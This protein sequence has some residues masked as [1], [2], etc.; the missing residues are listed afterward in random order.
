MLWSSRLTLL[1]GAWQSH[2]RPRVQ[3]GDTTIIGS[4]LQPSRLEF[5]GGIPFAEP[6][7]A[8][9]RF[10]PPRLKHSLSPLRSFNA[11]S[12]GLPCLQPYSEGDMS[13]NCLTLNVFRPNRMDKHSSLPVMVWIY[14]GGFYSGASS[15]YDGTPL[16][17]QSMAR[18]TPIIFVSL[19][20]R[21]GP[22]G[23]PQ[24]PEA[25]ERGALNLGLYDQWTALEWVQ[26]NIASFGGDP[27]KVTV[28]GESAGALSVSYHY[29]NENFCTVARA[30]I[31]QSGMGSTLPVFDAYR[32]TPS[33]TLFVNNTQ[34][35]ITASPNDAFSCLMSANSTDLRTAM[36]AAMALELFPF[37]PVLDG[38]DGILSD[39]PA[40][41]L[42]YGAGGQIPFM[43]GTTLDEGV[44]G[45][46]FIPKDFQRRDISVWL[47]A[48]FTPS[49]LGRGALKAGIQKTPSAGSPFGTGNETFGTGSGYKRASAIYG[50]VLFQAPRRFWSQTARSPLSADPA[51]GVYH[52]SDLA[53][54]FTDVAKDGSETA[55]LSRAML[56][57]WISFAV[58]LTPN[59]GK[60]TN[61][62]H[63][64]MY[65]ET[66]RI[67]ELNSNSTRLIP[68]TYR[69]LAMDT[70]I[71]MSDLLSW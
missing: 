39:H 8:N 31:F 42:S 20:Y 25:V 23:F 1:F 60:G 26:K 47:N 33:W 62:P 55:W 37:R 21:L 6:P 64:E 27:L 67:L 56:D 13:E 32:G 17:E 49:P 15:L 12:Y 10:S 70:T 2:T 46:A 69:S 28:F 71:K 9:L 63:W 68:D 5:F 66:K 36:N 35:C 51:L 48:N 61:R 18:G 40:R 19:N 34:S 22:L 65:E 44:T 4:S 54:L 50:D 45:T 43:T 30:A 53:Y 41:R 14:G 38:L 11:R 59:D 7:V 58:S 16:V 24:G 29:L 52:A 3:L 57:Y